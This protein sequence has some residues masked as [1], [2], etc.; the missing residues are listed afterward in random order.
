MAPAAKPA[1][2]PGPQK[3]SPQVAAL[4]GGFKKAG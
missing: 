2:Q 4:L 1:A 3:R